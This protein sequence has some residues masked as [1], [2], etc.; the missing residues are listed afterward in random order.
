MLCGIDNSHYFNTRLFVL[1]PINYVKFVIKTHDNENKIV[2]LHLPSFSVLECLN[3]FLITF[4]LL[5]IILYYDGLQH[6]FPIPAILFNENS[7]SII[8]FLL[9]RVVKFLKYLII[10]QP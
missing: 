7:K 10:Y 4:S 9:N 6:K 1:N 5:F 8:F 3:Q 2:D